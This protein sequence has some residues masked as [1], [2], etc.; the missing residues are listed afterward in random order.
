MTVNVSA[1]DIRQCLVTR[2]RRPAAEMLR[3]VLDPEGVVVPDI[4]RRLPGRGV[5][6]TADRDCLR[7]AVRRRL[8]GRGFKCEV[9]V[10]AELPET[11][12]RLL[13]D[14][15]LGALS[16]ARKSGL[17]VTGF[18]KTRA[19]LL[20]GDVGAL[21]AASD[22]AGD[23]RSKLLRLARANAEGH[24]RLPVV[25]VLGSE[26]LSGALGS[27]RVVHGALLRGGLTMAIC[28]KAARLG[29]FC[30]V[31]SATDITDPAG[32]EACATEKSSEQE[33]V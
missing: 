28:A 18:E 29:R 23:G 19:Q 2:E 32:P 31:P 9:R 33:A 10:D 17:V 20:K 14:D 4:K 8:F 21:I 22:G 5:W 25:D 16:L 15:A 24:N 13:R 11:V 30:G 6:V 27:E 12:E 3:F 1:N 7:E 26:A